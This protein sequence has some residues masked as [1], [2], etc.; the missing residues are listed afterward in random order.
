MTPRWAIVVATRN[1]GSRIVALIESVLRGDPD[2]DVELVIVDQS[3]DDTTRRAVAAFFTDGRVRY[4]H[5]DVAGTSHARNHGI[6]V[7]TAPFI[8]ITD[9]DCTVPSDWTAQLGAAFDRNP[10]IGVV[11]CNVDPVPTTEPGHTPH[12][13]FPGSRIVAGLGD[14]RARQPLW[15]GAGMALRRETVADVGG[16][17]EALGPGTRFGACEDNDIAWRALRRGWWVYEHAGTSV[18]HDGFRSLAQLGELSNRDFYGIGATI[19]KYLK[20]GHLRVAAML[21]PLFGRFL[22]VA[23]MRDLADR[24]IPRGWGRPWTLLRGVVAGLRV[25]VD[26]D[27]MLYGRPAR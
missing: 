18:R 19:A 10:R 6:A 15:M 13:R 25:P 17:D 26:R 7:T 4:E 22:F 23:P 16:F 14:L 9:D 1:R 3:D 8:A 2:A 12:I 21:V 24:R 5:L 11:Y 20:T 27:T